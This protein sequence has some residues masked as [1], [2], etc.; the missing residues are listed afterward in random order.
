MRLSKIFIITITSTFLFTGCIS[1]TKELPSYKTYSLDLKEIKKEKLSYS[2]SIEISEPKTIGS[3]NSKAIRYIKDNQN[4]AY[5]LSKWSDKPVKM[6]QQFIA[7]GL[8][9]KDNFKYVTTSNMKIKSDYRLKSELVHFNHKFE[10]NNSYAQLSIRVFLIN[11]YN[12]KVYFKNFNY[13][14]EASSNNALGFVNSINNISNN[15]LED[16]NKFIVQN[17]KTSK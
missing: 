16:L 15:F 10:E 4:E 13:K 8:S 14:E 11:N 17:I 5:V 6:I 2:S 1:L 12:E 7:N 3:L 9:L